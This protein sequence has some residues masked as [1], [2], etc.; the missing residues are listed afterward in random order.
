MHE[1]L[2]GEWEVVS[3]NIGGR[4][5][6]GNVG[7]RI[8]IR[9]GVI[10]DHHGSKTL[11]YSYEV[12]SSAEPK[13]MSWTMAGVEVDGQLQRVAMD[14]PSATGIYRLTADELTFCW[15]TPDKPIPESFEIGNDSECHTYV[16]KRVDTE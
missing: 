9:N 1:T 7:A 14:V 2:D 10:R 6:D 4:P 11:I 12:Q 13:R 8:E 16:L 3:S 5:D 15:T